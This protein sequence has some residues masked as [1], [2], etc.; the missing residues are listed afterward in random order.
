MAVGGP[1]LCEEGNRMVGLNQEATF[2]GLCSNKRTTSH[3]RADFSAPI[4]MSF[5]KGFP[6][7]SL[8]G[9]SSGKIQIP[10]VNPTLLV[11]LSGFL[12]LAAEGP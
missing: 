2:K 5:V 7:F 8:C 1:L 10:Y 9:L 12:F 4:S 11:S 6:F 3:E